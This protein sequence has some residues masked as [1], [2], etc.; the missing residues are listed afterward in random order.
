MVF[1]LSFPLIKNIKGFR[2]W[3]FVELWVSLWLIQAAVGIYGGDIHGR[4]K[5]TADAAPGGI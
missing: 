3:V 4:G 2:L 5:S 1:C